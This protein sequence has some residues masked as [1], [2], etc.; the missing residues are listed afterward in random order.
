ME[1]WSGKA[2]KT[3]QT[4]TQNFTLTHFQDFLETYS[5]A[6]YFYVKS[7]GGLKPGSWERFAP[8]L[9]QM[10]AVG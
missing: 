6:I 2:E 3:S 9:I 5:Q 8:A 1:R 4:A 7:M 10:Q